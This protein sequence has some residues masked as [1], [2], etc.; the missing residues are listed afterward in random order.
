MPK[1][2]YDTIYHILRNRIEDGTYA[3]QQL[4]P[5]EALLT[6]EFQCSRNTVRRAIELLSSEGLVQSVH[7]KGVVVIYEAEKHSIF[8]LNKIE[9]FTEASARNKLNYQT[10]ILLFSELK[11]D[12]HINRR[13]GFPI[14]CDIYYIQRLRYIEGVPLIVDHN[15]FRTDVAV[16][17]TKELAQ[18]SI[19]AYL[20]KTLGVIITTTKRVIRVDPITEHDEKHLQLDGCNCVAAVN[21]STYNSD[22]VMFE[23]TQSR[24]SPK[25]FEFH[26]ISHRNG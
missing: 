1:S 24:H 22:G 3:F 15:Y 23:F 17:L 16:G 8:S 12:D 21:N 9:S 5:S 19:Y 11:T 13:T 18:G 7:G 2:K 14:G 6:S 26:E 10:K 20:E 4:I 25:Y